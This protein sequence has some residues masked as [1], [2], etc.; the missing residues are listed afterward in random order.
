MPSS[1][2]EPVE[3]SRGKDD[4]DGSKGQWVQIA[5]GPLNAA[6]PGEDKSFHAK[7]HQTSFGSRD[8]QSQHVINTLKKVTFEDQGKVNGIV[9][10]VDDG[11]EETSLD[12]PVSQSRRDR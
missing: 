12:K 8:V 5:S 2:L 7:P 3:D 9:E 1:L 11:D 6:A 10:V 4:T